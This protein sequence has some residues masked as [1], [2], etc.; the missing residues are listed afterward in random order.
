MSKMMCGKVECIN[1]SVFLEPDASV[2]QTLLAVHTALK[3]LE[4][5]V[6]L[7]LQTYIND[8]CYKNLC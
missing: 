5:Q 7:V 1:N 4:Q 3:A 8:V 2:H 6:P